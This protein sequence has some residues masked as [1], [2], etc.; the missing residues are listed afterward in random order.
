MTILQINPNLLQD[1]I[2]CFQ[3]QFRKQVNGIPRYISIIYSV[4]FRYRRYYRLLIAKLS[5]L[6]STDTDLT[7]KE[8]RVVY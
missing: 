4:A 3:F 1:I 7:D 5:K 2:F 8:S 6:E